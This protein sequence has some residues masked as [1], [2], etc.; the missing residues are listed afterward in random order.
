M[1]FT[2]PKSTNLLLQNFM[3]QCLEGCK[4]SFSVFINSY[5]GI[6]YLDRKLLPCRKTKPTKCRERNCRF[7]NSENMWWAR[8]ISG[9]F[10][11]AVV[12]AMALSNAF[13][14]LDFSF[15]DKRVTLFLTLFLFPC[16]LHSAL[17]SE[18]KSSYIFK[19]M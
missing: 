12:L 17:G 1:F 14:N 5:I 8:P 4:M 18:K 11:Q 13:L 15:W 7:R 16:F 6:F 19:S 10:I 2:K 3:F 9:K